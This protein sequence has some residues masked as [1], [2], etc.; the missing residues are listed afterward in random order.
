MDIVIKGV[1]LTVAEAREL[2]K[3]LSE[4]FMLDKQDAKEETSEQG[5]TWIPI[6]PCNPCYPC[7]LQCP[8]RQQIYT[9]EVTSS[10]AIIPELMVI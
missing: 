5:Y 9:Y 4:L 6:T 7:G 8:Y 10:S 2:Y 3:E 1:T